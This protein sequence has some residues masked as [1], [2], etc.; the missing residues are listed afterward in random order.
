MNEIKNKKQTMKDEGL[1]TYKK[2]RDLIN[3]NNMYTMQYYF[4]SLQAVTHGFTFGVFYLTMF[5]QPSY[6]ISFVG[7]LYTSAMLYNNLSE[8]HFRARTINKVYLVMQSD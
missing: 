3:S 4:Y 5:M 7:A 8:Q 2:W 1:Y 6:L